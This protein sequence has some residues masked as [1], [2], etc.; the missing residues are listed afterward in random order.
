MRHDT[1]T[2]GVESFRI[3]EDLWYSHTYG[4][5]WYGMVPDAQ[6]YSIYVPL[7]TRN[8]QD[9]CG[10]IGTIMDHFQRLFT[11]F[12]SIVVLIESFMPRAIAV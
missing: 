1:L 12:W 4:M 6:Q 11:C 2:L 5:V 3:T 9:C 7:S 8:L 10:A